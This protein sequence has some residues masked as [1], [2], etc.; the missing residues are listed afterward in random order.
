[1]SALNVSSQS[2][3]EGHILPQLRDINVE[4]FRKDISES[5]LCKN[6]ADEIEPLCVQFH[7]VLSE[8]REK[9]A[10][11]VTKKV[12]LRPFSPWYNDEIRAEKRKDVDARDDM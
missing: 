9:H 2:H 11:K 12:T 10:S 6:P 4:N 5:S 1:M 3:K 8:L 7:E